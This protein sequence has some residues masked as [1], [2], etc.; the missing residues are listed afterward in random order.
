MGKMGCLTGLACLETNLGLA[1]QIETARNAN[2]VFLAHRASGQAQRLSETRGAL[3][4][5]AGY[6]G[7]LSG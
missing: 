1:Y 2:E 4:H 3:A 5:L 6:Y 7:E